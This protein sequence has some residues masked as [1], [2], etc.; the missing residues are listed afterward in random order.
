MTS[1]RPGFELPVLLVGAFRSLVDGLHVELSRH[2]H[3]QARPVHG[4]ALQA[5]GVEGASISELGRRLGVSKQA[6]AKTAASLEELGYAV[7]R[8]HPDD[9]RSRVLERTAR[10]V[11]ML[12][13]S[14]DIFENLRQ[15]WVQRLGAERVRALEADLE[16]IV[17]DAGGGGSLVDVPGWLR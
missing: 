11:E 9:R 2:G 5:L 4:F 17:H 16:A 12:A 10:G 13:L 15:H 7:R 3:D 6:A 8:A 14:A 1:E